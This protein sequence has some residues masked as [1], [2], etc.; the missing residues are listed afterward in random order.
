VAPVTEGCVALD[1]VGGFVSVKGGERATLP[2]AVDGDAGVMATVGDSCRWNRA[3]G[4]WG[5]F[6]DG[7]VL[8]LANPP[9]GVVANAGLAGVDVPFECRECLDDVDRFLR[10]LPSLLTLSAPALAFEADLLTPDVRLLLGVDGETST[11]GVPFSMSC[12]VFSSAAVPC[13]PSKK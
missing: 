13:I 3:E 2:P 12:F 1:V 9:L 6:L 10:I 8:L 11:G 7:T 5:D 4:I